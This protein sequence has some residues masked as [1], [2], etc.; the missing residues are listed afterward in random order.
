M[1]TWPSRWG[2]ACSVGPE[3]NEARDVLD[4]VELGASLARARTELQLAARRPHTPASVCDDSGELNRSVETV[5]SHAGPLA[6]PQDR[7]QKR[8]ISDR[9]TGLRRL[10]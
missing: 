2:I 4:P 8:S 1:Q 7:D 10:E 3:Y 5:A 9:I 6:R